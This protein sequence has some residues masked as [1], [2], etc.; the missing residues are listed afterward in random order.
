MAFE[1]ATGT[2][3]SI[4]VPIAYTDT[5]YVGGFAAWDETDY[6][7][8]DGLSMLP[9]AAG[10]FNVTN[11]DKP[12]GVIIGTNNRNP[13]F[14]STGKC[15]YITSA[16]PHDSTTEF[17]LTGG[18]YPG[19]A[20]E[21]MVK[22]DMVDACTVLRGPLVDSAMGT[23]PA[24]GTVSTGSGAG[25]GCTTSAMSVASIDGFS[26]IY[27][28]SGANKGSYRVNDNTASTT[29]FTWNIPLYA[30]VSEAAPWD[31][32]VLVNMLPFGLS[33]AQLLATY[34]GAFD[35]DE[36]CTSHYFGIDVLVLDLAEQYKESVT[37]RWNVHNWLQ[38]S[39]RD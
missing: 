27:F 29:T 1:R 5:M 32:A 13:V 28:R 24:V 2:P 31:T 26:T 38:A 33:R 7:D 36:A 14:N 11:Y 34:G 39:G 6:A 4:W 21:P 17:V 35:I 16:S 30:D 19:G 18:V 9:V 8:T 22:I 12:A 23:A 25:T 3:Y 37:F 15:E 20:R 10:A